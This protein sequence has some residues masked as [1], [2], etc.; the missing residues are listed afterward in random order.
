MLAIFSSHAKLITWTI[1]FFYH[2]SPT[3]TNIK[4]SPFSYWR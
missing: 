4:P 1:T 3:L 2:E